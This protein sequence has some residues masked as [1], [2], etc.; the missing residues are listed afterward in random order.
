MD[1][2][3]YLFDPETPREIAGVRLSAKVTTSTEDVGWLVDGRP[4]G[5]VAWPHE[6][7]FALSPGTHVIRAA[8]AHGA[9]ISAP[10][11][12]VVDD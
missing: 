7:R 10:V 11:T 1:R 9:E 3:R 5:K 2:S 6:L 4:V 8:L 12:V